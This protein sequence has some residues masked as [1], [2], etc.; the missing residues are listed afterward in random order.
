MQFLLNRLPPGCRRPRCRPALPLGRGPRGAPP[1]PGGGRYRYAHTRRLL[2]CPL[3][4]PFSHDEHRQAMRIVGP[5]RGAPPAFGQGAAYFCPVRRGR[6]PSFRP[7][8]AVVF[9][10][11]GAARA[12]RHPRQRRAA[13]VLARVCPAR[14]GV[15]VRWLLDL[16]R[17]M[18]GPP[19]RRLPSASECPQQVRQARARCG[20]PRL[21]RAPA[22]RRAGYARRGS[23][24]MRSCMLVLVWGGRT[25]MRSLSA[26]NTRRHVG[27]A[28]LLRVGWA[29]GTLIRHVHD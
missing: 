2:R 23:S 22:A 15:Y 20:P 16:P 26:R 19:T 9:W 29:A 11:G 13:L 17:P 25:C 18:A 27:R 8:L 5:A 24:S 14:S 28:V 6:Q 10:V 12:R 4:P 3:A 21:C 1:A 7:V